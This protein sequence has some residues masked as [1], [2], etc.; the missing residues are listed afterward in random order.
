MFPRAVCFYLCTQALTFNR[1]SRRV[2]DSGCFE[3]HRLLRELLARYLMTL[4]GVW[5]GD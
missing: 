5:W 1:V 2:G 4:D 3:H